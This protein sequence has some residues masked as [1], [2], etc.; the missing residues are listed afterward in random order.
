MPH[1]H[2]RGT[3]LPNDHS[4]SPHIHLAG[5]LAHDHEHS[6]GTGQVHHHEAPPVERK[7]V[8]DEFGF[9]GITDHEVDAIY[10]PATVSIT[11]TAGAAQSKLLS[12]PAMLHF[13]PGAPF[14]DALGACHTASRPPDEHAPGCAL[15]LALRALRI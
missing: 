9:S 10:L 1:G 12:T 2:A 5:D 7:F 13:V 11:A 15:Y 4:S 8:L 6:H 3:V 14:S